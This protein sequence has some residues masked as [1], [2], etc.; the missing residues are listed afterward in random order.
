MRWSWGPHSYCVME[1]VP[2]Q[3]ALSGTF[4]FVLE[5]FLLS[6]AAQRLDELVGTFVPVGP[7]HCGFRTTKKLYFGKEGHTNLYMDESLI[8]FQGPETQ[9]W[10]RPVWVISSIFSYHY[11]QQSTFCEFDSHPPRLVTCRSV[12]LRFFHR[13]YQPFVGSVIHNLDKIVS[14][15]WR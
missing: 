9:N 4:C 13:H 5:E 6:E 11:L 1:C 7:F 10:P 12:W 3:E 8:Y 14:C 15:L 2:N